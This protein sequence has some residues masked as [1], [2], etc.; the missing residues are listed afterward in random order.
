MEKSKLLSLRLGL[1]QINSVVGDLSGNTERIIEFIHKAK[2]MKVD[3]LVFP[4]LAL[5]G[6]PPERLLLN[7]QFIKNNIDCLQCIVQESQG[8]TL[9]IGFA[10]YYNG[11]V[12]NAAAVAVD[13]K[14][15]AVS[16]KEHRSNLPTSD[17]KDY[18]DAGNGCLRTFIRGH[19]VEI[20]IGEDVK[21]AVGIVSATSGVL[22]RL[23]I[24]INANPNQIQDIYKQEDS[25]SPKAANSKIFVACANLVGAQ[26]GLVFAGSSFILGD[27]G[28]ILARGK[29]FMEDISVADLNLGTVVPLKSTLPVNKEKRI[30]SITAVYNSLVLGIKDYVNKNGFS[31]VVLGLSGGIDSSL[32]ATLSAEALGVENVMG[33][34]M[35]SR[36]SSSRSKTDVDALVSSIG[37][38]LRIIPLEKVFCAYLDMLNLNI[39]NNIPGITEQNLQ[40]RVRANILYALSNKFGWM[41]L[42]CGNKS[43]SAT[44]YGTLYGDMAGG[45]AVLKNI[46]KTMVFELA[47]YRNSLAQREIIPAS[48]ILKEPSAELAPNQKDTDALPPYDVLDS[49][50]QAYI[51]RNMPVNE[52]VDMGYNREMVNKVA[53]L[54]DRNEYKRRQAP[55][56][57]IICSDQ[58]V[59]KGRLP[60]SNRFRV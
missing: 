55:P 41:V 18:F 9:V 30:N 33:V 17:E 47:S 54:V 49:I 38:K 52:I 57:V 10:D 51:D 15:V 20:A 42:S 12:Y 50:L 4:E 44:G 21:D 16:H 45:F 59:H 39:E 43:E 26:D 27:D 5:T 36:Y 37:I 58:D 19:D 31:K 1:A 60:I 23:L 11:S 40:A 13:N 32:V 56:G 34:Y 7:R 8:I 2:S 25:F 28:E 29:P 22:P 14:L 46:Y 35:P 53:Y 3:L 6:S 48:I 24:N